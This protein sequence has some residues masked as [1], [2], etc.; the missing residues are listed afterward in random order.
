VKLRAGFVH[1]GRQPSCSSGLASDAR[2]N[3]L[4][5]SGDEFGYDGWADQPEHVDTDSGGQ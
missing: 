1:P 4:T 3:V 2:L 5:G